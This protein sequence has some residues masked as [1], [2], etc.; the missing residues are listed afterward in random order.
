M[1]KKKIHLYNRLLFQQASDGLTR[2][3]SDRMASS[4][5]APQQRPHVEHI[6]TRKLTSRNVPSSRNV[7]RSKGGRD[8]LVFM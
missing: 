3:S 8:R 4:Q 1:N 2:S 7:A 5:V 6:Q